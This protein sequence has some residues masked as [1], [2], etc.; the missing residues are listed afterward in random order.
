MHILDRPP[1]CPTLFP[2]VKKHTNITTLGTP[3]CAPADL[4]LN[5]G[6]IG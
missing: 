4:G 6:N 5:P 3:G 1:T 2:Y